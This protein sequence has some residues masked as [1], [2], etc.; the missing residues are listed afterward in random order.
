MRR[1]EHTESLDPI[2]RFIFN[3]L[4]QIQHKI[5]YHREGYGHDTPLS[6]FLKRNEL[7]LWIKAQSALELLAE[8]ERYI[9][10]SI[11]L[12]RRSIKELAG[13]YSRSSIYRIRPQAMRRF[14][15]CLHA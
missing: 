7:E 3:E 5:T 10:K 8:H 11:Y 2:C 9:L 12:D 14:L 1:I 4:L 6:Q 15:D 13:E